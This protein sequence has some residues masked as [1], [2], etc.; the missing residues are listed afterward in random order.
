MQEAPEP[1]PAAPPAFRGLRDFPDL[2]PPMLV[3]ELRQGLKGRAFVIPFLVLQ[4]V[5]I[6]AV[7]EGGRQPAY[8]FWT[9]I[10]IVLLFLLPSRSLSALGEERDANTLDTLVLTRL[11][12]WRIVSGKWAASAAYSLL[13]AVSVIPYL[14][15]R[16]LYSGSNMIQDLVL[17][18]G[19]LL[20]S[21]T[22]AAVFMVLSLVKSPLTRNVFAW[23]VVLGV[24]FQVWLP[25][26]SHVL[27]GSTGIGFLTA[28]EGLVLMC[29]FTGFFLWHAAGRIAPA[30]ANIVLP[31]RLVTLGAVV[32]WALLSWL[33][34]AA[35]DSYLLLPVLAV[36]GFVEM[37]GAGPLYA[38][39]GGDPLRRESRGIRGG[40]V[41]HP[42]WEGGVCFSLLVWAVAGLAGAAE[43]WS[44]PALAAFCF[45]PVAVHLIP[46]R[47]IRVTTPVL[48]VVALAVYFLQWLLTDAGMPS[49]F[50]PAFEEHARSLWAS[51]TIAFLWAGVAV[52]LASVSLAWKTAKAR[53]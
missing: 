5:L 31:R 44:F 20:L 19:L 3:K 25:V 27:E 13:V 33:A 52:L 26:Q 42:G 15:I 7:S 14:L 53:K 37:G 21:G 12:P 40:V 10:A 28:V 39:P 49:A 9:A 8:A 38:T 24:H 1:A 48:L 2:I 34:G 50:L 23:A 18:C 46:S 51:W 47:G 36:A 29:W 35:A 32:V 11:T 45:L 6:P 4:G 41:F 30:A 43:L 22:V 17:L 16:Y